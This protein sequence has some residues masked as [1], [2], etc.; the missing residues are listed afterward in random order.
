M[1][2]KLTIILL[3]ASILFILFCGCY[4]PPPDDDDGDIHSDTLEVNITYPEDG[5]T[6]AA[7][8]IVRAETNSPPDFVQFILAASSY[9]TD[10][11]Y[12]FEAI[13]DIS[14]YS[15]GNY[16]LKALAR[17]DR[18]YDDDEITIYIAQLECDYDSIVLGGITIPDD[19]VIRNTV[20]CVVALN[21]SE[22]GLSD[23]NCLEGLETYSAALETIDLRWNSL[24]TI[25]L[26]PLQECENLKTLKL[27]ENQITHIDL[28]PLANCQN[29]WWLSLGNNELDSIDVSPLANCNNLY[30]FDLYYNH[31]VK[32]DVSPLVDVSSLK[33]LWLNGNNLDETSCSTVCDFIVQRP[34][35]FVLHDCTCTKY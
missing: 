29:L 25:D 14:E 4:N 16:T 12:P 15:S 26:S 20:G 31:I 17:W 33:K 32:I 34:D 22:M 30:W 23:S 8:L 5:D 10:Y 35:C 13:F 2:S 27:S 21:L 7:S 3:F 28:S 19:R 1:F 18:E 9:T 11:T 24:T 6:V